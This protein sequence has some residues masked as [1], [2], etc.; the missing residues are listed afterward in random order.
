V[1]HGPQAIKLASSAKLIGGNVAVRTTNAAIEMLGATGYME[2]GRAEKLYRDAKVLQ[3]Y[4]GPQFVQKTL[5]AD[6]ATRRSRIAK[7]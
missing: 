7:D 2:A 5:I 1:E 6:T 4:E 3:I